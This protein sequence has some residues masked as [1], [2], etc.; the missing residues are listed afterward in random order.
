MLRACCCGCVLIVRQFRLESFG[1]GHTVAVRPCNF[2]GHLVC[3][4]GRPGSWYCIVYSERKFG[5]SNTVV[6]AVLVEQCTHGWQVGVPRWIC[7]IH[8]LF[9]ARLRFRCVCGFEA[10]EMNSIREEIDQRNI[11]T[12]E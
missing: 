5:S 11:S 10:C 7:R 8:W 4:C 3:R 9:V 12:P 1:F 6:I 2:T